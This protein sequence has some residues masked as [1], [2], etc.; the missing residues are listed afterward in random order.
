MMN[1]PVSSLYT[2][3]RLLTL[4]F[5]LNSAVDVGV[6]LSCVASSRTFLTV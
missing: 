1:A 6:A 4:S 2:I 5:L 3:G